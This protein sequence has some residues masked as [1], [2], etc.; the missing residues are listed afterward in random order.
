MVKNPESIEIRA[1]DELRPVA[2]SLPLARTLGAIALRGFIEVA[3]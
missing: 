1:P 2:G 3:D